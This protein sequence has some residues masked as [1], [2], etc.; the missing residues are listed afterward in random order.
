MMFNKSIKI[1]DKIYYL[2]KKN[3]MSN[4][5]L[6]NKKAFKRIINNI[7]VLKKVVIFNFNFQ[8]IISIII[9]P[10]N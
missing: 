6:K 7:I 10:K 5:S 2:N 3:L 1:L 9:M 8:R 4:N